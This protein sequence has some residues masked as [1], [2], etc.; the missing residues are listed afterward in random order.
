MIEYDLVPQLTPHFIVDK[1]QFIQNYGELQVTESDTDLSVEWLFEVGSY[2]WSTQTTGNYTARV[3]PDSFHGISMQWDIERQGLITPSEIEFEVDNID[4]SLSKSS[5]EGKYCTIILMINESECRRWKFKVKSVIQSYDIMHLYCVDILQ[6]HLLGT[7]PNTAHPREVWVSESHEVEDNDSYRVP[8]VFGQ[9]YIPLMYVYRASDNTGYYVL[10]KDQNYDITEVMSPPS[11]GKWKWVNTEYAFTQ[12]ADKGY[13]IAEFAIAPGVAPGTYDAGTWDSGL[14]PL[15]QYKVS[16]G[17]AS[18][19]PADMLKTILQDFGVPATD[20]DTATWAT[21]K[22]IF[23]S[24]GIQWQGAFYESEQRETIINSLLSQCDANF[25]ISDKIELLPF[26]KTSVETFDKS[27]TIKGSFSS[28][29]I[30]REP[31]DSGRVQWCKSGTPQNDLSGKALLPITPEGTTDRPGGSAFQARFINNSVV[32][33][34]LGILHFQRKVASENISF[35]TSGNVMSSLS[36]LKPGHVITVNDPLFGGTQKIVVTELEIGKNLEVRVSGVR[37]AQLNDFHD[38]SATDISISGDGSSPSLGFSPT[39]KILQL[40]STSQ[41]FKFDSKGDPDP[42]EQVITFTAHEQNLDDGNYKFTTIPNVKS[43]TGASNEFTLNLAEFGNNENVKVTVAKD[44]LTNYV[45]VFKLKDGVADISPI[46]EIQGWNFD[47]TFSAHDADIVKWTAGTITFSSGQGFSIAPGSTGNMTGRSYIYFS[48]THSEINLHV[49]K[50]AS[51]AVGMNKVLMAVASP[52]DVEASFFVFGGS[53][54]VN[55]TANNIAARSI[56]ANE[57]A[58]NSLDA[59]VIKTSSLI[60]G[61]LS[62]AGDL[63]SMNRSD[64]NY[65]DGADNTTTS[66]NGGVITTG[67]IRNS[68]STMVIDFNNSTI[69]VK[70]DDRL[71]IDGQAIRLAYN[72]QLM[73]TMGTSSYGTGITS[74]NWL[75]LYGAGWVRL[76]SGA[77][78][79]SDGIDIQTSGADIILDP[80]KGSVVPY[81]DNY[82]PLGGP[83]DRWKEVWAGDGTINTSD[84][85]E[86]SNIQDSDFGLD[87]INELRPKKWIWNGRKRPHYGLLA[88]DVESVMLAEGKDFAGLIKNNL[89]KVLRDKEADGKSIKEEVIVETKDLKARETPLETWDSYGL[90]YHEFIGP[91]IKAIQELSNKIDATKHREER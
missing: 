52:G 76:V 34:K 56:T 41:I 53:G 86:K 75:S 26:S 74:T 30:V 71:V 18:L 5:I 14:Q 43:Q 61:D 55:L 67:V 90:R 1:A 23:A 6:G 13:K 10:G 84:A 44:G 46:L 68:A 15:V 11:K 72:G 4:G 38:I 45:T 27:K 21:A 2:K 80:G 79:H 89:S 64:L 91:M 82:T 70:G 73:G 7:Y 66:I 36:S 59:S 32:A 17:D 83:Y 9:A 31:I 22:N 3:L 47:G 54:G 40:K 88:Q 20:I 25:Y 81:S 29:N 49:T 28:S 58:L 42:A 12:Y 65:T 63:A 57:V 16:G 69:T 48:Q 50:V 37:L 24:Q 62:G 8:V 51:E 35:S 60:V 19:S 85:K 77:G 33:Q 39:A 78:E 87:F